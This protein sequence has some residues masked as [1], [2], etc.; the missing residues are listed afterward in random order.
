MTRYLD[1]DQS[2]YDV[3]NEVIHSRF[4]AYGTLTF[5]FIFDTKKRVQ[6][7][8]I[9]LASIEVSNEK[10]RFLTKEDTEDG[11]GY[12]CVMIIDSVAWEYADAEDRRRL[13]S[14]ELNHIFIDEK[15]KLRAVDHDVQDFRVEVARNVDKPDWAFKLATLVETI[16]SQK[17]DQ[18]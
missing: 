18:N 15:G 11:D 4:P 13:I 5:K 7:G 2:V 1:V 14:H 9:T 16:Y 3:F 8:A 12:D 10:V 6:K 17:E